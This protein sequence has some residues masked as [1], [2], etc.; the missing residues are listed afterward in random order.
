[1]DHLA[2]YQYIFPILTKNN[3][4]HMRVVNTF[5]EIIELTLDWSPILMNYYRI[6][7]YA[8]EYA[9]NLMLQDYIVWKRVCD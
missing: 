9:T 8:F 5:I 6:N 2:I 7:F 4:M 1:M 3:S